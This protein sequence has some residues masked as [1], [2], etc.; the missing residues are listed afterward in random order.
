MDSQFEYGPRYGADQTEETPWMGAGASVVQ[1]T[2][3]GQFNESARRGL[4]YSACTPL[5][6]L[7]AIAA[8]NLSPLPANTGQPLVGLFVPS[9]A[10]FKVYITRA[11]IWSVSGTPGAG[12]FAWNIIPQSIITG[13]STRGVSHLTGALES[14]ASVY[15]NTVTTGSQAGVLIRGIGPSNFA[16]ALAAGA[17]QLLYEEL[18][19]GDIVCAPGNMVALAAP[20]A[21]ATWIVGASLTWVEVPSTVS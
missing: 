1:H 9:N 16:G 7:A 20:A 5:T 19:D 11:K 17:G 10:N 6:G 8:A 4:V 12:A 18:T 2:V 14:G 3:F 13:A 15:L 21:G